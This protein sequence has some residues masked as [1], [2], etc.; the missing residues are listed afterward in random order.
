VTEAVKFSDDTVL[1]LA[2]YFRFQWEPVQEAHVLLYPEGMVKLSGSA[3]E[4]M[5]RVNGSATVKSIIEDL[6]KTFPGIDLRNDVMGF[7]EVAHGNGWIR[8]KQG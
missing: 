7:L 2:R 6:G 1:D 5:K 3:G 8:V 4:I